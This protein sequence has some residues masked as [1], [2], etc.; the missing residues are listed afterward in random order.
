MPSQS[1]IYVIFRG[2]TSI[3]DWVN[4]LDAVLTTYPRCSGCEVHKGFYTAQQGV[5]STITGY[6]QSLKAKYPSYTVVVTGHSLGTSY[7]SAE[8]QWSVVEVH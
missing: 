2:S 3:Q 8:A 6:V 4:N 5:I 1:S 7:L